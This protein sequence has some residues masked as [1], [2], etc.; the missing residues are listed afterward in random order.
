[1]PSWVDNST[2]TAADAILAVVNREALTKVSETFSDR[3]DKTLVKTTEDDRVLATL[4]RVVDG[5]NGGKNLSSDISEIAQ[6]ISHQE[7]RAE[8]IDNLMLTHDY[9][10][11]IRYVKARDHLENFLLDC[12]MRGDL[13]PAEALAFQKLVMDESSKIMDRVKS[14]ATSVKDIIGLM[15]KVDYTVT[16]SE[17]QLQ[18]QFAKTTPQGRE[19][20]RRLTHRL[21]KLQRQK[22]PVSEG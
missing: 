15:N 21:A 9:S 17:K 11:L 13:S 10:R 18:R 8:L 16:L 12:A 14:G 6:L 19:V 2:S 20:V 4:Q 3:S 5:I 1:M 22:K 7:D